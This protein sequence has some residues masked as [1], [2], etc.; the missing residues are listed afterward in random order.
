MS[1]E[2]ETMNVTTFKANC[3]SVL[4]GIQKR[5][6][7]LTVTSRGIPLVTIYPSQHDSDKRVFGGQPET[8]RITGEI[9]E[10]DLSEDWESLT[11]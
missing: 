3:I 5:R 9:V 4:K 7:P 10:T 6:T 11:P 1:D 8:V 2:N